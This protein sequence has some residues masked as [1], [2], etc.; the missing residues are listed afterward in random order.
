MT[1]SDHIQ[2]IDRLRALPKETEWFDFEGSHCEPHVL[3][4]YLPALANAACLTGQPCGY[5]AFGI[6]DATH[7][8]VGTQFDPCSIKAQGN[9]NLLP[10]LAAGLHPNTGFE[11]HIVEHTGG[12]VVLRGTGRHAA[13]Y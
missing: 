11:T 3:G 7:D 12:R 8:V 13:T 5:L 6:D 10:W 9:Q 4:E 2:L 1:E